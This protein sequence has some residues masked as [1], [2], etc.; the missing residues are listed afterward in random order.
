MKTAPRVVTGEEAVSCLTRAHSGLGGSRAT[1]SAH[2]QLKHEA[3]K[4]SALVCVV[5]RALYQ[6]IPTTCLPQGARGEHKFPVAAA[7]GRLPGGDSWRQSGK[8]RGPL[9]AGHARRLA[10]APRRAFQVEMGSAN[11]RRAG[12]LWSTQQ[13]RSGTAAPGPGRPNVGW[14]GAPAS[15]AGGLSERGQGKAPRKPYLWGRAETSQVQSPGRE[16]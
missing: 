5:C 16:G 13:P 3:G 10:S 12:C 7:L 15:L 6:N 8:R 11:S 2:K 4:Q 9:Q 14:Q 1:Q